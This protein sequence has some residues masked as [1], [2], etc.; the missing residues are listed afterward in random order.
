[1]RL[2]LAAWTLALTATAQAA[3]HAK[4]QPASPALVARARIVSGNLQTARAFVSTAAAKYVTDFPAPLVVAVDA[5]PLE[6]ELR[7]VRFRCATKGCTLAPAEQ[8]DNVDNVH[9]VRT[10]ARTGDGKTIA[11]KFV[12]DPSAKDADVV[13]GRASLHVAIEAARPEAT[14]TLTATPILQDFERAVPA[15][16]T[17]TSR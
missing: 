11:D 8:G 6:G 3:P 14:Y 4:P 1:M 13:D 9:A 2:A 10:P 15:S 7:R 17:L 16:F 5:R 12:V